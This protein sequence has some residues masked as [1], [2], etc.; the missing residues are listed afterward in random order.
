LKIVFVIA[1]VAEKARAFVLGTVFR[2]GLARVHTLQQSKET[3]Q[4]QTL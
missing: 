3:D 1:D 2:M 4:G